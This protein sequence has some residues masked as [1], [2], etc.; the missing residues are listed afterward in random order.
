M[1]GRVVSTSME[2]P[3]AGDTARAAGR[4]VPG[5]PFTTQLWS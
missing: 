3:L 4:K 5:A 2:T 1:P